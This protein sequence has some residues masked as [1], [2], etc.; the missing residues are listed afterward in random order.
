MTRSDRQIQQ[1]CRVG[2]RIWNFEKFER[3]WRPRRL[4]WP[5]QFLEN[6]H[7]FYDTKYFLGSQNEIFELKIPSRQDSVIKFLGNSWM[8]KCGYLKF[9]LTLT[10][11]AN[12]FFNCKIKSRINSE[13]S[14]HSIGVVF[15]L[16]DNISLLVSYNDEINFARML[17]TINI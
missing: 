2:R 14:H 3:T 16:L 11:Y 17:T 1:F 6:F 12:R 7:K 10:F 8:C 13:T 5:E 4:K 15:V 9:C